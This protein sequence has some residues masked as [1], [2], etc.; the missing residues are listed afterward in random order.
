MIGRLLWNGVQTDSGARSHLGCWGSRTSRASPASR[1]SWF[2]PPGLFRKL[3]KSAGLIGVS[4]HTP[5][6]QLATRRLRVLG[7]S[8]SSIERVRGFL[9]ALSRVSRVSLVSR[10][11]RAYCGALGVRCPRQSRVLPQVQC[12][13]PWGLD[14][15]RRSCQLRSSD[16]CPGVPYQLGTLFPPA[17]F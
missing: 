5:P 6:L 9:G 7:Y 1:T 10:A 13:L 12:P 3:D 8:M 14:L 2:P 4:S 15:G 11:F 16:L 17:S